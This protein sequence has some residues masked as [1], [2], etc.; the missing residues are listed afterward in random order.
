[1]SG[2]YAYV[3]PAT[4]W[5]DVARLALLESKNHYSYAQNLGYFKSLYNVLSI[6][7]IAQSFRESLRDIPK[8]FNALKTAGSAKELVKQKDTIIGL[9]SNLT[10]IYDTVIGLDRSGAAELG[11]PEIDSRVMFI[12]GAVSSGGWSVLGDISKSMFIENAKYS[13]NYEMKKA[14]LSS[15][16]TYHAQLLHELAVKDD[17]SA[18]EVSEFFFHAKR[19]TVLKQLE[20]LMDME[21]RISLW[22]EN[23][24]L[25][26]RVYDFFN[27]IDANAALQEDLAD[28]E[29]ILN[30]YSQAEYYLESMMSEMGIEGNW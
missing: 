25:M 18:E 23:P 5:E 7:Y 3:S 13:I 26:T 14:L 16:L 1:L 28:Y 20:A 2:P 24:D 21:D 15:S 11:F 10:G 27:I 22:Q 8:Q 9:T 19:I 12:I 29:V 4:S 17:I 6:F 30:N